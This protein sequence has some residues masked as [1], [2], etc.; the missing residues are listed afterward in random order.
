MWTP[1]QAHERGLSQAAGAS[2][3][4]APWNGRAR[5][6]TACVLRSGTLRAPSWRGSGWVANETEVRPKP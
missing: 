5:T 3:A 4:R 6:L 1:S 2:P